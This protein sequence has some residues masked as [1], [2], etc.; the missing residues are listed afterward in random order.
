MSVQTYVCNPG[1]FDE[2]NLYI[3]DLWHRTFCRYPCKGIAHSSFYRDP[4][5]EILHTIF[6][7]SQRELAED[8]VV[9]LSQSPKNSTNSRVFILPNSNLYFHFYCPFDCQFV[10]PNSDSLCFLQSK[11]GCSFH[12]FKN[13][14]KTDYLFLLLQTPERLLP[15]KTEVIGIR[16]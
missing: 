1:M 16:Q 6:S 7:P 10:L 11:C 8:T 12:R 4:V 14:K 9:S 13:G 5:K 2:G 15:V 3:Q